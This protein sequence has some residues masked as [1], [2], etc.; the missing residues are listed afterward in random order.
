MKAFLMGD[1]LSHYGC[2]QSCRIKEELLIGCMKDIKGF[3]SKNAAQNRNRFFAFYGPFESEVKYFLKF[4][5]KKRGKIFRQ[6]VKV[7]TKLKL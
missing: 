5:F 2:N 7:R 4:I 3:P 1:L 6:Q